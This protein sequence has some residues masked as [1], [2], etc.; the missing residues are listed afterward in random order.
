ML[1]SIAI[2]CS[3]FCYAINIILMRRQSLVADPLE[4]TFFQSVV[5][6]CSLAIVVPFGRHIGLA[7]RRM[8]GA[9]ARSLPRDLP[10]C[11]SLSWAYARADASYLATTEYTALPL[12]GAVRLADLRR[13]ALAATPWRVRC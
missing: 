6:V 7:R 8:A 11:C 13:A 2:L 4:I 1:G 9:A 3:A 5:A 10:R 12:G